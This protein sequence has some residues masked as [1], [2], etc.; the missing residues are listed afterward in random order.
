MRAVR[1]GLEVALG[2]GLGPQIDERDPRAKGWRHLCR[3]SCPALSRGGVAICQRARQ[4][5]G[6]REPKDGGF[7]DGKPWERQ[8]LKPQGSPSLL[9]CPRR[10]AQSPAHPLT[11]RHL[12][13]SVWPG[14]LQKG[15]HCPPGADGRPY[16]VRARLRREPDLFGQKILA[17]L[18]AT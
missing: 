7:H 12:Q 5:A 2:E 8:V 4:L 6:A 18:T 11:C 9:C 14:S 15:Q 10:E 3:D 13:G 17:P 1:V 16:G